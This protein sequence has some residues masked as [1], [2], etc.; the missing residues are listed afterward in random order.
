MSPWPQSPDRLKN[1]AENDAISS[2]KPPPVAPPTSQEDWAAAHWEKVKLMIET[3]E[4]RN[5]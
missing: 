4:K 1:D 5:D 2:H 3:N